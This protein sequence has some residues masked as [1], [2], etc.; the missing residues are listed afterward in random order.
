MDAYSMQTEI[1]LNFRCCYVTASMRAHLSRALVVI[2]GLYLYAINV[3][4]MQSE[5]ISSL[6]VEVRNLKSRK[7][8][9][10]MIRLIWR[11]AAAL[12]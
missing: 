6:T 8:G 9:V 11:D 7:A 3:N 12:A 4:A 5:A 10:T 1:P 2:H